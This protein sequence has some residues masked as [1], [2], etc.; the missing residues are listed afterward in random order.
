MTPTPCGERCAEEGQFIQLWAE[1]TI[2]R[3]G[4]A[5][6]ETAQAVTAT[7]VTALLAAVSELTGEVHRSNVELARVRTTGAMFLLFAAVIAFVIT[8]AVSLWR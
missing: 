4:I 7:Q 8:T 2:R 6:V 5:K 1:M 3:E